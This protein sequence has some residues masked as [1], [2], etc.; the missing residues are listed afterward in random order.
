MANK[1][2]HLL[3][4]VVNAKGGKCR[5]DLV[6]CLT[7]N[8]SYLLLFVGS[9]LEGTVQPNQ[10]LAMEHGSLFPVSGNRTCCSL[11][12]MHAHLSLLPPL[13]GKL[14]KML[15]FSAEMMAFLL[16]RHDSG[17]AGHVLH[18]PLRLARQ[19][20]GG[21]VQSTWAILCLA[22]NPQV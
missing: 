17:P 1:N 10:V 11:S 6:A 22:L 3:R 7:V 9:W 4:V 21:N 15:D 13:P 19:G 16:H 5:E 14:L 20:L 2:I 8:V 18:E 12:G